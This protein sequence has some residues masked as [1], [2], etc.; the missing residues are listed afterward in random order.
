MTATL[1][2][3]ATVVLVRDDPR[4]AQVFVLRRPDR[5]SFAGAWVF[6]G[7]LVEPGDPDAAAAGR[8]ETREEVGLVIERGLVPLS[9]W[10]PPIGIAKRAKT[11]FFIAADPGGD[12]LLQPGEA[13]EAIWARPEDLLKRHGSGDLQLVPPTFVTLTGLQG[14]TSFAELAARA[15]FTDY[16]TS[17]RPGQDGPIFRWQGDAEYDEDGVDGPHHRVH[18]GRLPW[19]YETPA[20]SIPR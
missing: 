1:P 13:E 20:T 14:A 16:R 10:T 4:G 11:F 19:V 5:G 2:E 9:V 17:M 12:V 6:P 7:G 3:A 8:R 15:T 18:T